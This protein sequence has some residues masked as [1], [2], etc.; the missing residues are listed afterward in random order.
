[1]S[2]KKRVAVYLRHKEPIEDISYHVLQDE[3]YQALVGAHENY[4]LTEICVDEGPVKNQTEF[5]RLIDNCRAG[6][7]DMIIARSVSQ[8]GRNQIGAIEM[9]QYLSHLEPP[10]GVFFEQECLDSLHKDSTIILSL[11]LLMGMEERRIRSEI[12]KRAWQRKLDSLS[13]T[14][15]EGADND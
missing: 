2:M 5:K 8:F 3:H 11:L 6:N 4:Q 1:M 7:I 10:V 13:H 14:K 15:E 12:Q 9:A